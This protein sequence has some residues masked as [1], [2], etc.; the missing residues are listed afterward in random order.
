MKYK[1]DY[2]GYVYKW[3]NLDNGKK[4]IGSHYGSVDDYYKGSGKD[5]MIDYKKNPESFIMEVLEYVTTNDKKLVLD[6]EQK[7]LDSI[8]D[9]K[10]HNDYYNLNNNAVGGFGYITN[11]HITARA[12]TL[13]E[14]HA[15]H[16]L[17]DAEKMSYKQKIKTRLERISNTGFT[18]KEKEQHSKYGYKVSITMPNGEQRIYNSCGQASRELGIDVQYGLKVCNKKFDFKGYKIVK[19]QDPIIDCR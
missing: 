19:L 13:R 16:G 11:D 9:I 15:R 2:F 14:K 1:E 7:W 4:Y 10:S 6:T 12:A 18:D 5:F 8:P 17:S 3:T